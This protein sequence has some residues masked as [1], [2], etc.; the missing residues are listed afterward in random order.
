V[1]QQETHENPLNDLP[2]SETTF[3][4]LVSL[5]D[6]PKHGYAIMQE[7]Q[8]FS[9]GRVMLSTGTL[10]GAIKRMLRED[11]IRRIEQLDEAQDDRGRKYYVLTKRGRR[12]LDA[13][14]DRLRELVAIAGRKLASGAQRS[15]D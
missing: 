9:N 11:W 8:S 5:G 12:V 14:T 1:S 7:V 13:E 3:M 15:G 10:Y 2:L 6:G 4:I